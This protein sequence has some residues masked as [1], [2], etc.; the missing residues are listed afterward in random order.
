[1]ELAPRGDD[2]A[3]RAHPLALGLR[4]GLAVAWALSVWCG[5]QPPSETLRVWLYAPPS[6][7]TNGAQAQQLLQG[8]Q[9]LLKQRGASA[10]LSWVFPTSKQLGQIHVLV[11]AGP[12]ALA[13][14]EEQRAA[15]QTFV[16]RGGGLVLLEDAAAT[17]DPDWMLRLTGGTLARATNVWLSGRLPVRL[18]GSA[19]PI[20]DR[21]AL[22]DL[23]ARFATAIQLGT[24]AQVIASALLNP[25]QALPQGWVYE[26]SGGRVVALLP[27]LGPDGL[28]LAH[29]RGLVL[30]SV[31]WAAR[32]D[33][34]TLLRAEEL[35]SFEWPEG[36][37]TRAQEAVNR[38]R[39]RAEFDLEPVA[40]EPLVVNPV[41]LDWDARGRLWVAMMP[42]PLAGAAST[43]LQS[44]VVCCLTDT[45][46]DGRPDTR[47]VFYESHRPITA[48]T[49]Y[50][51]G[52]I[53]AQPPEILWLCDADGDGVLDRRQVLYQGFGTNDP[54]TSL[55]HFRWGLDGWVYGAQGRSGLHSTAIT[56]ADGRL[57]G[58]IGPGLFRFKP[59]G[60]AIEQVLSLTNNVWGFDFT[61]DGELLFAQASGSHLSQVLVPDRFLGPDRPERLVTYVSLPDH[62]HLAALRWDGWLEQGRFGSGTNLFRSAAGLLVYQ[63]GAWPARY[64][65]SCLVCEPR[66]GV[67]HE[68]LISTTDQMTWEATRREEDELLA[69]SDLWFHPI[70]LRSG[71]DGAVYVLDFYS[72]T[73]FWLGE[74]RLGLAAEEPTAAAGPGLGPYGRI[75]R[76][77]H[78]AARRLAVPALEGVG[79]AQWVQALEHPNAWVRLTAHRLLVESADPS[80]G[81]RL[82]ALL[83]NRLPYVRVHAL[84]AL[85]Q[86][87]L[88]QPDQIAMVLTNN[89]HVLV[90]RAACRAAEA[91]AGPF[92]APLQ[93]ALI[94][95]LRNADERT[96]LLG[97]LGLRNAAADTN[98]IQTALR[99]FPDLSSPAMRAAIQALARQAPM[100][101]V[102]A[103]FASSR[104]EA[105]RD[106]VVP[107]ADRFGK[108]RDRAALAQLVELAAAHRNRAERLAAAVLEAVNCWIGPEVEPAWSTSLEDALRRLLTANNRTVRL[109]ALP[110]ATLREDR[111]ELM[112]LAETVR[113]QALAELRDPLLRDEDRAAL[114]TNLFKVKFLQPQLLS[115]LEEM[116]RGDTVAAVKRQII[117]ELGRLAHPQATAILARNYSVV[118]E[119]LRPSL[120]SSLSLKVEGAGTLLDALERA[121]VPAKDLDLVSIQRLRHHP[122]PA[123]AQRAVAVFD[124]LD[125]APRADRQAVLAQFV[126]VTNGFG[127]RAPRD[128]Y[129]QGRP[130]YHQHCEPCHRFATHASKQPWA[131]DLTGAGA[132]GPE[133]VLRRILDPNRASD[134]RWWAWNV[135]TTQGMHYLGAL[136]PGSP[137]RVRLRTRQGTVEIPAAEVAATNC[138]GASLMPEGFERLGFEAIRNLLAYVVNHAPQ[139]FRPLDLGSVATVDSRYPVFDPTTSSPEFQ[140]T[141][142]G[143]VSVNP[144][145]VPFHILNPAEAPG[146]RNLLVLR[147]GPLQQLPQRVELRWGA[148]PSGSDTGAVLGGQAASGKGLR[149]SRL[150]VL[151]GV[152]GW[153]YPFGNAPQ[154]AAPAAKLVFEYSDGVIDEL[155]LH[156]GDQFAD[157]SQVIDVPGSTLATNMVER[158][159]IRW[160]TVELKRRQPVRRL[161][162]ESFNNHLAPVFV[163]LTAQE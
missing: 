128:W 143:M 15:L 68:D 14:A 69:S 21:I 8:W 83:T 146:G 135:V 129:E 125:D 66:A 117:A 142:F 35:A 29:W 77:Q 9:N 51:Q 154:Q 86:L 49:F 122:D 58:P 54:R 120:L 84:W 28:R 12:Q 141:R 118:P 70:Q 88:L 115:V 56:G 72:R 7:G 75:W 144:G 73:G 76:L 1:M 53:V 102:R 19:H 30:R 87:G 109:A 46:R 156:N 45:N 148:E 150:H 107:L 153:G 10:R 17:H 133:W 80:V 20:T 104:S 96:R 155:V 108:E 124:R 50:R 22:F 2:K 151:G 130:L 149:A 71:P 79:P 48:F 90:Q 110:L 136:E 99:M 106:L 13:L 24:Q 31:A 52:L 134:S 11:V 92:T 94:R 162:L 25:E 97:L 36:G 145:N 114:V 5:C 89:P 93:N 55:S 140:F 160:F 161:T 59:D 33:A 62:H 40:A 67:I 81:L 43:N 47:T 16:Q 23:Q 34:D 123:V 91:Y 26:G 132:A 4:L 85:Q 38:I 137:D 152:A 18:A 65:A 157:P 63:G 100:D 37:P 101:Y 95:E 32:R 127:D 119:D 41:A 61:W 74:R 147:G 138:T 131:I 163:A 105:Y 27:G 103:A 44:S 116:L 57:F 60:S 126:R 112:Q 98:V 111:A 78:K 64:D 82:T 6:A 121:E 158:G 42:W 39:V 159:Q 113:D 139:G 3:G